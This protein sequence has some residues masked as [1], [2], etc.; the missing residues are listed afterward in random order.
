MTRMNT[1]IGDLV[2]LFYAEY[3]AIYGDEE[4]ASIAT[5]AT[6]NDLLLERAERAAEQDQEEDAA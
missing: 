6:I 2:Q 4:L 1:N 3:M 5:A